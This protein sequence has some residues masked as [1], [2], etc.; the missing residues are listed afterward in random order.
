MPLAIVPCLLHYFIETQPL[1]KFEFYYLPQFPVDHVPCI[2]YINAT[3]I[4]TFILILFRLHLLHWFD[5]LELSST[6]H[7]SLE[8]LFLI[9]LLLH[10][11]I[12]PRLQI[13]L[14]ISPVVYLT[15]QLLFC[16]PICHTSVCSYLSIS[17]RILHQTT[18][19]M[20]LTIVSW[21]FFPSNTLLARTITL[22]CH[23]WYILASFYVSQPLSIF[24]LPLAFTYNLG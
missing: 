10:S 23:L 1:K 7:V 13:L 19:F 22:W 14:N 12:Y 6:C 20:P 17:L 21:A 3:G 24:R 5:L 2:P 4:I 15:R 11:G 9:Y 8:P 18:S 16:L